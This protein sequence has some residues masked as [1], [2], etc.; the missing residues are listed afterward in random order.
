MNLVYLAN[1]ALPSFNRALCKAQ[2]WNL[3][4]HAVKNC[5]LLENP[6]KI[7]GNV[8][9]NLEFANSICND[10][11]HFFSF[12]I[13]WW[14]FFLGMHIFAH[15]SL[16]ALVV[17]LSCW[18]LSVFTS[19]NFIVSSCS[20]K[21]ILSSVRIKQCLGDI[22][23]LIDQSWHYRSIWSIVMMYIQCLTSRGINY[24]RRKQ[25]HQ[26]HQPT[27][28]KGQIPKIFLAAIWLTGCHETW[29]Q[30]HFCKETMV[31][32]FETK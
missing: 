32:L 17:I 5:V 21:R 14:V 19:R 29:T 1:P 27:L 3:K 2:A 11:V 31:E 8:F 22:S 23:K 16:F 20:R 15:Q 18:Q 4:S 6:Y 12:W 10:C 7:S 9:F 24:V 30:D 13:F 26:Q 28:S 25:K